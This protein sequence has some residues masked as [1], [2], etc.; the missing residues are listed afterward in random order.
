MRSG[1]ASSAALVPKPESDGTKAAPRW[2]A[3]AATS[4]ETSS[5]V[6]QGASP[7]MVRNPSSPPARRLLG[8]RHGLRMA[9]VGALDQAVGATAPRQLHDLRIR[10]DH[11]DGPGKSRDESLENIVEHRARQLPPFPD[12]EEGNQALLGIDQVLDGHCREEPH[13]RTSSTRRARAISSSRVA[14]MVCAM[15]GETPSWRTSG[16]SWRS[17]SSRISTSSQGA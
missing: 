9:A 7:G 6:T 11:D 13:A 8:E 10:R 17:R 1:G 15:T 5:A 16:T 2:F 12:R 14:M 3:S 4:V